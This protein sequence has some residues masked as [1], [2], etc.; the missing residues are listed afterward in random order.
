MME[1]ESLTN[2]KGSSLERT[3]S[4]EM[5]EMAS[6]KEPKEIGQMIEKMSEYEIVNNYTEPVSG[7]HGNIRK[8]KIKDVEKQKRLNLKS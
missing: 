7:R 8:K 2:L 3:D 6:D 5:K 1:D 4:K